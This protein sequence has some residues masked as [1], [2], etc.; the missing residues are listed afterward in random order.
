MYL[1]DAI[2]KI[3]QDNGKAMHIKKIAEQLN[4]T[5]FYTKKDKSLIQ[6]SQVSIRVRKAP[7][8]QMFDYNRAIVS[9]R[10]GIKVTEAKEDQPSTHS[11][12]KTIIKTDRTS[13]V[14]ISLKIANSIKNYENYFSAEHLEERVPAK[15][16]IYSLRLINSKSL[17]KEYQ[18]NFKRQPH[19]IIYI[20]QA[21]K[22]LKNRL[23]SELRSKGN[24]TFFRSLGAVLGYR[25]PK[26]SLV[27]KKNQK[28]YKFSKQ[29]QLEIIEWINKN[30]ELVFYE[31]D[32]NL[33]KIES[34][35]IK[36]YSPLL[37]ISHNPKRLKQLSQLRAECIK[38]ATT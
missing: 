31:V 12:N 15:A 37:N 29:D 13:T 1:H 6:P 5:K 9:L 34:D 10:N 22:D 17:P 21:S 38:I 4:R 19:E 33:N 25:P 16:G 20:G 18:E 23:Q 8:N 7:Y 14:S 27:G 32:K 3:L 26:G 28:N 30:L 11:T 36:E 24:G 35:L 2:Y